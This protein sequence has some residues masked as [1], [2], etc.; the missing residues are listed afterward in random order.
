MIFQ[1]RNKS[2]G[3]LMMQYEADAMV[4]YGG[5]LGDANTCVQLQAP[6]PA[7]SSS[8]R[9]LAT[10]V[11]Q[12]DDQGNWQLVE[13]ASKLVSWKQL[14][15]KNAL[16]TFKA[17]QDADTETYIQSA[18]L[19]ATGQDA[20]YTTHLSIVANC[21]D[22]VQ[23]PADNQLTLSGTLISGSNVVAQLAST[24][25][26][27]VGSTVSGNGI[28]SGATVTSVIDNNSIELSVA[29]TADAT[30]EPIVLDATAVAQATLAV[31]RLVFKQIQTLRKTR[32]ANV[33]AYVP[34]YT[35]VSPLYPA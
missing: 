14:Q 30:G 32:D 21:Q 29:A 8:D 9:S 16:D 35:D 15:N 22:I 17:Q 6:S 24:S 5:M 28:A 23:F 7:N 3:A 10:L 33:A 27:I 25:G 2:D 31:Y 26:I 1:I 20:D 13:D 4:T 34:P 11:A 19:N 12:L 18:L